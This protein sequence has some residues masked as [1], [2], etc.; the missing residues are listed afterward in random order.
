[1]YNQ[2]NETNFNETAKGYL[3]RAIKIM[4]ENDDK[5]TDNLTEEQEERLFSALRWS[6]SEMT[7]ED[8]RKEYENYRK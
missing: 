7:M 2:V 3:V 1:M 6:F 4:H 5:Y 8:A